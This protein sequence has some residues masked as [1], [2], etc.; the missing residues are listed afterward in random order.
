MPRTSFPSTTSRDIEEALAEAGYAGDDAKAWRRRSR[1]LLNATTLKPG[2]VLSVGLEVRGEQA[3][4]SCASAS[5]TGTRH[6]LTVALDDRE[7]DRSDGRAGAQSG[8]C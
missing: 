7:R 1:T 2:T 8:D 6:L 5:T 3:E 4:W